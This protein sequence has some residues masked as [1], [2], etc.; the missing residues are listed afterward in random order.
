M[1]N[2][3]I[4]VKLTKL[5]L[6]KAMMGRVIYSTYNEHEALLDLRSAFYLMQK[7][8]VFEL[9]KDITEMLYH[10]KNRVRPTRLPYPIVFIETELKLPNVEKRYPNI[11][12][13]SVTSDEEGYGHIKFSLYSEYNYAPYTRSKEYRI[14]KKERDML[15]E[16]IM[17][18]LDF[19][20]NP[21]VQIIEVLRSPKAQKKRLRKGK[22]PLPPSKVVKVTGV[23][24]KYINALKLGRHF[25]YSHRFWVRGHWRHLKSPRFRFKR[26]MRVWIPPFIK[27][28]GILIDKTYKLV[29]KRKMG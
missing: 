29:D 14:W 26:G 15:R 8:K 21:E 5:M 12:I 22:I 10:T 25:T 24:K 18:F 19:L 1:K 9:D 16:F 27:G 17:S 28:S 7:A 2:F 11:Y 20:H 3:Q 13:Y 23:L 6:Q 4:T